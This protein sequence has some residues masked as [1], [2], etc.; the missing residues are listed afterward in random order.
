MYGV[1]FQTCQFKVTWLYVFILC[2]F[3]KNCNLQ[4]CSC[5]IVC[6]RNSWFISLNFLCT[7]SFQ[8]ERWALLT[9]KWKRNVKGIFWYLSTL[10]DKNFLNNFKLFG[11][12][13]RSSGSERERKTWQQWNVSFDTSLV[14]AGYSI[15]TQANDSR[16]ES[17]MWCTQCASIW[18]DDSTSI[19]FL[20]R[21]GLH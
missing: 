15:V 2:N 16:A 9:S 19:T 10:K 1:S 17:F 20:P 3:F 12:S 5:Q 6:S 13:G 11:W 18:R 14:M 21:S 4:T 8:N 7:L